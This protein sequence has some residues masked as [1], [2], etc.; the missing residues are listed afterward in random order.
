MNVQYSPKSHNDFCKPCSEIC[1]I[2]YPIIAHHW[3]QSSGT[4]L[5][6]VGRRCGLDTV[7]FGSANF[8]ELLGAHDA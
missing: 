6:C 5:P 3:T 4:E 8:V 7:E 2:Q 1:P